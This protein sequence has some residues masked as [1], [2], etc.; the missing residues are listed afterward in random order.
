M[1]VTVG[2]DLSTTFELHGPSPPSLALSVERGL[3]LQNAVLVRQLQLQL[4]LLR[5]QLGQFL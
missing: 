2:P 4:L 3:L 5:A 1:P